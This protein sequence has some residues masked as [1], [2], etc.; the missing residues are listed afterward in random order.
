MRHLILTTLMV[1]ASAMSFLWLTACGQRA[2]ADPNAE[3]PP[4]AQVY[5]P[6]Q[7]DILVVEK[8][9]HFHLVEAG[10]V[11]DISE[12]NV[13]GTVNP[14]VSRQVP[15][16]SLASGRVIEIDAKLGDAVER[17]QRMLRIQSNDIAL[18]YQNREM[19]AA[20][21]KLA[22]SQLARA[23]LLLDKG[24][25]AQKDYDVALDAEEKAAVQL[26]TTTEALRILGVDPDHPNTVVDVNAPIAGVVVEQNVVNA[27]GVKTLDN[28]P[29]LFTI[30]DLS[31]VWIICDVYENDLAD[32]SVGDNARVQLNAYPARSFQAR[33]VKISPVLDPALRTAKVRLEL[34]N[35]GGIMR[36]GMFATAT[37]YA[38]KKQT[39]T[40]V[41]ATA[42]LHLR[43]KDWVFE[44][45]GG[46]RFRKVEVVGGEIRG[47]TQRI[48]SGLAP[49]QKVV[50]E[51]L[52]LS[53]EAGQ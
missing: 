1:A 17:G 3:A 36:I 43:D 6:R 47:S 37:F 12:L 22:R 31:T 27:G 49:G 42:V 48:L 2:K 11:Q 4:P 9:E 8:P 41:P 52:Q 18:A 10:Q 7:A 40:T 26:R 30:A 35:P 29:N 34:P 51:A 38:R 21:E 53:T 20:D 13:T 14:D 44:P 23:K 24:A 39:Y 28:S 25:L 46:T 33:V 16:I 32:V 15:V 5:E 19:A 50:V 45:A